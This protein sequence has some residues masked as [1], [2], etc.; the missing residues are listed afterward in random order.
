M[1]AIRYFSSFFLLLF[2]SNFSF[3]IHSEDADPADQTRIKRINKI[4]KWLAMKL[5][6]FEQSEK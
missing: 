4:V 2:Y 5:C 1:S 6:E 3:F